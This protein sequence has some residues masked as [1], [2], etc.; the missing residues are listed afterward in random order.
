MR[1]ELRLALLLCVLALLP[2]CVSG[3]AAVGMAAV[4]YGSMAYDGYGLAKDHL[5]RDSIDYRQRFSV[6][7]HIV[8]RRIGE[9]FDTDDDLRDADVEAYSVGGHVYLI[10]TYQTP[11]QIDRAADIASGVE[12]VRVVTS[13]MYPSSQCV[14]LRAESDDAEARILSG[15]GDDA[16]RDSL[17]VDVVGDNAVLLG[18]VGS[19][20]EKRRVEH[21][22]GSTR[23]IKNV[24]SYLAVAR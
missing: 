21:L 2:G 22:A 12:G 4:Q 16:F 20:Q 23:G 7:D 5:P 3:V 8:E 17:R 6:S 14:A 13:C 19:D 9:R 15:V 18:L 10:G 24:V 11:D 1:H